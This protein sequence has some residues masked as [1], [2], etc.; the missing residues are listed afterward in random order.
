MDGSVVYFLL[1]SPTHSTP[2]LSSSNLFDVLGVSSA[3]SAAVL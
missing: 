2:L 1:F 3:D